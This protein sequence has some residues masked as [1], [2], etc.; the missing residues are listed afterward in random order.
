MRYRL[1]ALLIV[2]TVVCLLLALLVRLRAVGQ[3]TLNGSQ[4]VVCRPFILGGV[5]LSSNGKSVIANFGS[6]TILVDAQRIDV[7]GHRSRTVHLPVSWAR[8]ELIQS[9]ND[10]QILSK[11]FS[12]ESWGSS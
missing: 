12:T 10:V 9:A 6:Q 1:R 11:S 5:G 8:V 2:V 7:F 4:V 3:A